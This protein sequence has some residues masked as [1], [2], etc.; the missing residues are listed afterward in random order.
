MGSQ[1]QVP[2]MRKNPKNCHLWKTHRPG[3]VAES[4]REHYAQQKYKVQVGTDYSDQPAH[5]TF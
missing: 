5:H 2:E 4:F 1:P 3:I